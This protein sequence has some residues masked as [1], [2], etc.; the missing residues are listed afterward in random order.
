MVV[1]EERRPVPKA[2]GGE[3]GIGYSEYRKNQE[4]RKQKQADAFLDRLG[5]ELF[6]PAHPPIH[7]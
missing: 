1:V 6:P 2:Y 7:G 3:R 5:S 4:K